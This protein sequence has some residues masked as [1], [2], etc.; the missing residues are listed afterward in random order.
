M[1][2]DILSTLKFQFHSENGSIKCLVFADK[3]IVESI[4]A[5][6]RGED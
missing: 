3:K 4:N 1:I 2:I 5:L 6:I